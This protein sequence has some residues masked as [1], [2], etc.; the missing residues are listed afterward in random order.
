MCCSEREA[1]ARKQREALWFTGYPSPDKS[2]THAGAL[3]N[4]ISRHLHQRQTDLPYKALLDPLVNSG[5]HMFYGSTRRRLE[6]A[7]LVLALPRP[8]QPLDYRNALRTEGRAL[9]PGALDRAA[10]TPSPRR[11]DRHTRPNSPPGGPDPR[12]RQRP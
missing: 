5:A 1:A 10:H 2:G 7:A 6:I 4:G 8:G 12:S 11:R 3:R 9:E